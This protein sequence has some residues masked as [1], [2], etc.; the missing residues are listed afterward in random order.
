ML[1]VHRQKTRDRVDY[2]QDNMI[3]AQGMPKHV[4][5]YIRELLKVIGDDV[6]EAKSDASAF[7][8]QNPKM[9]MLKKKKG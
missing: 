4:K 8:S 9:S 7:L 5:D 3:S 1:S 2:I 6:A